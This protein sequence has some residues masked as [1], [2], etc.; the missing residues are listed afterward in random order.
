M[1]K[2]VY[3]VLIVIMAIVI[4]LTMVLL[5]NNLSGKDSG[6]EASPSPS[7]SAAPSP[8]PSV[9]PSAEPS[10]S[11]SELPSESPSPSPEEEEIVIREETEK[12]AL[13][14]IKASDLVTYRL[15][16]NESVL[17]HTGNL[18]GQ[19][20]LSAEDENEYLKIYYIKDASPDELAPSFLNDF[21]AF[22][23]FEQSGAEYIPGTGVPGE[24]IAVNDGVTQVEAWLVKTDYDVLAVV[25]S[26]TLS[27]K[28]TQ[29]AQLNA[30]LK[31]FEIKP[32][33]ALGWAEVNTSTG[34]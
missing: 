30:V 5:I 7:V 33:D 12:G 9:T 24:K 19:T 34:G 21:I 2:T 25:I 26:Y 13:Y 23:E 1:K 6:A 32:I 17:T 22:T 16:I 29:S 10:P 20:F 27:E 8:S 15:M 11:P 3:I 14:T 18:D 31:T 4:I 28:D